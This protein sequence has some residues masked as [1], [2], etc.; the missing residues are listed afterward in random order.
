M[1]LESAPICRR[2]KPLYLELYLS[3]SDELY[4]MLE[5]SRGDSARSR[6]SIALK[7]FKQSTDHGMSVTGLGPF[8]GSSGLLYVT[9]YNAEQRW[10]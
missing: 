7:S 6:P 1:S 9:R 10:R 4:F 2:V 8:W 3:G 5:E